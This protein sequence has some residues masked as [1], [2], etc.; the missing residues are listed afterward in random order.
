MGCKWYTRHRDFA[1][2]ITDTDKLY[3]CFIEN[4]NLIVDTLKFGL[5]KE[6]LESKILLKFYQIRL[7]LLKSQFFILNE[8]LQRSP[9]IPGNCKQCSW[10]CIYDDDDDHDDDDDV[11]TRRFVSYVKQHFTSLLPSNNMFKKDLELLFAN[12]GVRRF[13]LDLLYTS[14]DYYH[15]VVSK[16]NRCIYYLVAKHVSLQLSEVLV[17][18]FLNEIISI[19]H[20]ILKWYISGCVYGISSRKEKVLEVGAELVRKFCLDMC[21]LLSADAFVDMYREFAPNVHYSANTLKIVNSH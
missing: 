11:D 6:P 15:L 13:D 4:Y 5:N 2:T 18:T 16:R 14:K 19:V 7:E 3:N 9:S 17:R 8:L 21:K 1:K 20:G 12:A 10:S